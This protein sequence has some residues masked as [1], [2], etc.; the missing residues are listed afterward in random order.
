ML[1]FKVL[2]TDNFILRELNYSDT[3]ELYLICSQIDIKYYIPGFYANSI[4]DINHFFA[5]GNL[6]NSLLLEIENSDKKIIG[7]IYAYIDNNCNFAKITYLLDNAEKGK[8]IMTEALKL[9][10]NFLYNS[11]IVN[12]VIFDIKVNNTASIH[13][14]KNLNIP[15]STDEDYLKFHLSLAQ[16]L[17]F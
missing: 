16:K 1:N 3:E 13:I 2:K 8:G 11:K 12:N 15:Y 5:L 14:M 9:F 7:I 4:E 6:D 17:P 10:I